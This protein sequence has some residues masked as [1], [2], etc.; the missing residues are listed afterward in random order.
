MIP[1]KWKDDNFGHFGNKDSKKIED[2]GAISG[3]AAYDVAKCRY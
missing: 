1:S 3:T 2:D